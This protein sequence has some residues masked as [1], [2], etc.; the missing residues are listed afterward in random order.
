MDMFKNL[1]H[2]MQI[3]EYTNN[4]VQL[5]TTIYY[6]LLHSTT[7]YYTLLHSTTL[8]YTLLH[9]TTLSTTTLLQSTTLYYTLLHSTT[10]YYTLLHSTTLYYTL[11]LLSTTIYYNLLHSTTIYYNLLQ[12]TP[13][14]PGT[15]YNRPQNVFYSMNTVIW[16]N[17]ECGQLGWPW[18]TQSNGLSNRIKGEN[19]WRPK[20]HFNIMDER[21]T[22]CIWFV[23]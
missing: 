8:Y 23:L 20:I 15:Y 7:L 13:R 4:R 2:K 3:R 9:S 18:T 19:H 6:N 21:K 14:T 5:I 12:S 11:L 1:W 16:K 22:I 17:L 10:L